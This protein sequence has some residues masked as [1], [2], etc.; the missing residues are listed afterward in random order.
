MVA[1]GSVVAHDFV[2]AKAF[3]TPHIS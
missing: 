2:R 1:G 3:H